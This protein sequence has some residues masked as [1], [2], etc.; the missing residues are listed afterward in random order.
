MSKSAIYWGAFLLT[1]GSLLLINKFATIES[2]FVIFI[3]LWP[4]FLIFWGL[5]LIH[6]PE[7]IRKMLTAVS[8]IF[9]A[10]FLFA[11]ITNGIRSV[12]THIFYIHD[13]V[14]KHTTNTSKKLKQYFDPAITSANLKINFGVGDLTV[15]NSKDSSLI[16]EGIFFDFKKK[17]VPGNPNR[18]ALEIATEGENI[19]GSID[20]DD[21]L[22]VLLPKHID[23]Y[24]EANLGAADAEFDYSKLKI[25]SLKINCGASDI[26]VRLGDESRLQEIDI[27]SGASDIT[28]YI[29][30]ES[31]CRIVSNSFLSDL[32]LKGFTQNNNTW[33]SRNYNSAENKIEVNLD[34][35]VSAFEVIRY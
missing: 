9:L 31:G 29:P 22:Y 6:F 2:E 28:L 7:H 19:I 15:L 23:W 30:S 34:G 4:M 35:A 27:N 32:D 14:S 24:I 10:L 26:E 1:F 12:K 33:E 5:S 3:S 18:M 21:R 20:S 17:E 16:S 8:A 25:F 11:I 13:K